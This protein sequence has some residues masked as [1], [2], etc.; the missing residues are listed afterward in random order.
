M[1]DL[2]KYL[3]KATKLPP[4]ILIKKV[5]R[6]INNEIYYSIRANKI[7]KN[8]I[9][10]DSN[11]FENF[12]PT[13][14]FLFDI[15]NKKEHYIQELKKSKKEKQT[16]TQA[17]KICDHVFNLLGSGDVN[18]GKEIKWNEDFKSGFIWENKFYKNIKIVDLNTWSGIFS[19][20]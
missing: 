19:Y 2:K 8:P 15:N 3:K 17:N 11:M 10:I 20:G 5:Y 9:D 14:N 12:K 16:I 13:I 18:L 6:K 7:S 4:E 1:S